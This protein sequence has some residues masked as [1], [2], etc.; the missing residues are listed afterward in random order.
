VLELM[1]CHQKFLK[2][3]KNFGLL[4]QVSCREL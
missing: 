4:E 3:E 1:E 2:K